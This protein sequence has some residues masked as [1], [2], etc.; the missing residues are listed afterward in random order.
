RDRAVVEG[1]GLPGAARRIMAELALLAGVVLDR[2]GRAIARGQAPDVL[3]VQLPG[4]RVGDRVGALRVGPTRAVLEIIEAVLAH[5]R[6]LDAAEVDP[7]VRVLMAEQRREAEKFLAFELAPGARV[8]LGP[9]GPG[10]AADGL[11]RRAEREDVDQH[12]LVVAAP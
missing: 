4:H 1:V 10:V 11:V 9:R 12:A 2:R 6:V 3:A 5:V 7:D 8:A